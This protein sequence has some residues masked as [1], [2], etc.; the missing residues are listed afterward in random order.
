MRFKGKKSDVT[1]FIF[2]LLF[3]SILLPSNKALAGWADDLVRQ[4]PDVVGGGSNKP[5]NQQNQGA[6]VQRACNSV[7]GRN[8]WGQLGCLFGGS[9]INKLGEQDQENLAKSTEE[10]IATGESSGWTNPDSGVHG[11]VKVTGTQ[12]T[13]QISE[14]A[15]QDTVQE[16]PPLD[17]IGSEFRAVSDANI[18]AGPGTQYRSVG[19]VQNGQAIQVIAKVQNQP[20]Y[21]VSQGGIGSGYVYSDSLKPTGQIGRSIASKP[22]PQ[23]QVKRVK[24]PTKKTCKTVEQKD[25]LSDGS[26]HKDS[27]EACP[28]PDGSWDMA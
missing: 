27:I 4:L 6:N 11:E 9:L 12:E 5:D 8:T 28:N 25:E 2:S 20:W 13:T 21:L 3:I 24:V 15:V 17:L 26:T 16:V 19:F 1:V 18:F 7:L 22:K 14:V 23:G 10:T